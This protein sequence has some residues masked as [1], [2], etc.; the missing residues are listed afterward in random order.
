MQDDKTQ[1]FNKAGGNR[2]Q[3][4][5]KEQFN[6]KTKDVGFSTKTFT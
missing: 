3:V 1:N 6:R 2:C 4:E 5:K